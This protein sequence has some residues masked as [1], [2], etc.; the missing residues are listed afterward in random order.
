MR[1][2][3]RDFEAAL[4]KAGDSGIKGLSGSCFDIL[5]HKKAL[6]TFVDED[7]VEPTNNEAEREIRA[8][9]LWRKKSFGAQ[10]ER[11]HL[12]AERIMTVAHTSRKQKRSVLS[13]LTETCRARIERRPLPSLFAA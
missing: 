5:H 8:F 2:V 7:G 4:Q 9:V 11:G 1:P 10:S 12:F 3:R 6:F 13:F